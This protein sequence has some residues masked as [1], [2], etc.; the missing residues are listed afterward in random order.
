[1]QLYDEYVQ[2][3]T[4]KNSSQQ[5]VINAMVQ[6]G[7]PQ[8]PGMEGAH[9]EIV[10]DAS[11]INEHIIPIAKS[12]NEIA[13]FAYL[14]AGRFPRF[15]SDIELETFFHGPGPIT[16]DMLSF[17]YISDEPGHIDVVDWFVEITEELT[18]EQRVS[19]VRLLSGSPVPPLESTKEWYTVIT[20]DYPNEND[21]REIQAYKSTLEI[22]I[23]LYS[24]KTVLKQKLLTSLLAQDDTVI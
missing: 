5:S 8:R 14:V 20:V 13:R 12:V 10:V 2:I 23:P 21:S 9:P 11:I 16:T 18:R 7:I 4:D 19:L 1:M 17:E 22:E 6:A 24:S 15:L 3:A